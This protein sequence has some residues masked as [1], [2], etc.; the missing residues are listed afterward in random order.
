MPKLIPL[1]F[2]VDDANQWDV[3]ISSA[4]NCDWVV[5]IFPLC[6]FPL[7]NV[8]HCIEGLEMRGRLFCPP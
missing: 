7:F 2:S 8:I 4:L 3:D 1:H 6:F 5:S